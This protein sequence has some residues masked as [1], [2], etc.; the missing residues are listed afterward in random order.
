MN[1]KDLAKVMYIAEHTNFG[2]QLGV[3]SGDLADAIHKGQWGSVVTDALHAAAL[4]KWQGLCFDG[5][6]DLN[7]LD[8]CFEWAKRVIVIAD[9][10]D[11]HAEV[12]S[13]VEAKRERGWTSP[14]FNLA[15]E[16]SDSR[17]RLVEVD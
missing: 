2:D 14:S 3:M 8:E 16:S 11:R 12:K 17:F 10:D 7:M 5:T 9:L 4:F 1:R 6:W 13:V 15:I